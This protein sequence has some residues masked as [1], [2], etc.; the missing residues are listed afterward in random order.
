MIVL[1]IAHKVM[2]MMTF[3]IMIMMRGFDNFRYGVRSM[4]PVGVWVPWEKC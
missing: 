3:Y 1:Q 4:A 2:I